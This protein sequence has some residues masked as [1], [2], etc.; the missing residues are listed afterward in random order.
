MQTI[1]SL[2]PAGAMVEPHAPTLGILTLLR[3]GSEDKVWLEE[4]EMHPPHSPP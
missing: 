3:L 2:P 1:P 4:G